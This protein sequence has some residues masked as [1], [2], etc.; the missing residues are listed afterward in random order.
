MIT[1]TRKRA[2]WLLALGF[3]PLFVTQ[4]AFAA[5]ERSC[6]MRDAALPTNQITYVLCEQ[7]LLLV[8]K[9][10]GATW[11]Q[12]KIPIE[13]S[14]LRAVSFHDV[15]RGL[16][17]GDDGSIFATEDA[18]GTWAARKSGTTENLTDIQMIGE[19][20]WIAGYD[21]VILHT[22]D[23]GKTWARQDSGSAMSLEALYFHDVQNGWAVGWAGTILHTVDGG[24]KWQS[25]KVNGASWSLSSITFNDPQN[26]WIVGF[27]GQFLAT[28]DGGATWEARKPPAQTWLTS[29][30]FD[31]KKRGWITT[32][33]GFLMS[34]DG[35]QTWTVKP[36]EGQLFINRIVR[37]T[38]TAWAL[39][40]FGMLKQSGTG[41]EWKKIPN[42]LAASAAPED[43]VTFTAPVTTGK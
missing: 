37:T 40:P 33:I 39:G 1:T 27:A 42:P 36:T 23:G 10:D 29:I 15:N 9:D 3:A 8:T 28:K 17:V 35:G 38:G 16:V 34:E 14:I 21:G 11:A 30:G 2:G 22:A 4:A 43:P 6:N 26:G 20:G 13:N 12:R 5:E 25:L 7:G 24:R 19:E 32:D 41:L 31:S 18:G